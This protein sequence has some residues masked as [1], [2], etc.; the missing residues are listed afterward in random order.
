MEIFIFSMHE[1]EFFG[2]LYEKI[3]LTFLDRKSGALRKMP[4]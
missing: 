1:F 3:S 2:K 4:V